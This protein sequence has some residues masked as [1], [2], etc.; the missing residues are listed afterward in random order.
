MTLQRRQEREWVA[1]YSEDIHNALDEA[2][3]SEMMHRLIDVRPDGIRHSVLEELM[4]WSDGDTP[5]V[6]AVEKAERLGGG[7]FGKVFDG[8]VVDVFLHA[9]GNNQH[10]IAKAYTKSEVVENA[11]EYEATLVDE[12]WPDA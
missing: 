4:K 1:E 10:I 7:F 6:E 11:T 8:D 5:T 12:R 9:D 2:G 3:A